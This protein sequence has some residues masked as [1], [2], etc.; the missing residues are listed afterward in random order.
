MSYFEQSEKQGSRAE[1]RGSYLTKR[2]K[3]ILDFIKDFVKDHEYAPS[4]REIGEF[5]D[6]KSVATVAEHIALLQEKG[7][8]TKDPTMARSLQLTPVWEDRIFEVP[9]LGTIAAGAPI[10]AIRTHET[11]QIPKDMMAK[12]V[13][14]LKVRGES[15]IDEGIYDGDYVIIQPC[16]EARNGEIVVAL[17]D[18][19]NVTLKR[20]FKEKKTIRLEAANAKM[21]PMRF[22]K[23]TIQ[24]RVKGVIRKFR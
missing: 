21:K 6:Y 1:A 22:K 4:F 19:E 15:M 24:G 7:F 14:A 3:E 10:Q 18:N 2:Q 12:N 8:L 13:F 16:Q 9:L 17:V 20:F 23:V 11:I 5:F